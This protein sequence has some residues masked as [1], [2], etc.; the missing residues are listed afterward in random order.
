M[1]RFNNNIL[2]TLLVLLSL[3]SPE[4]YF[5]FL[6]VWAVWFKSFAHILS[7]GKF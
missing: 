3:L 4:Q 7:S 1:K 2:V 5:N 6:R